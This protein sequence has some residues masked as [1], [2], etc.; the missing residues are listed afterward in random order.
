MSWN[1]ST[2]IGG[3]IHVET[4][5]SFNTIDSGGTVGANVILEGGTFDVDANTT[6]SGILTHTASST[7]DVATG[8][9]LTYSHA[10]VVNIGANTLNLTGPGSIDITGGGAFTLNDANSKLQLTGEASTSTATISHVAVGTTDLTN[11]DAIDLVSDFTISNFETAANTGITLAAA[12]TLTIGGTVS[13]PSGKT[14]TYT[15]TSGGTLKFTDTL[16][17]A[18]TFTTANGA[19]LDLQGVDVT[20]S[21]DLDTSAA[22]GSLLTDSTT[23]LTLTGS[24]ATRTLTTAAAHTVQSVTFDTNTLA[25]GD[26]NSDLTVIDPVAIAASGEGITTNGADLS[27]SDTL[28]LSAGTLSSSG[29]TVTVTGALT[30]TN[31]SL[32]TSG[33]SL[34]LNGT[35]SGGALDVSNTTVTQNGDL[36][37]SGLSGANL[38]NT[39][40]TINTQTNTLTWDGQ[41]NSLAETLNIGNGTTGAV[42]NI[43]GSTANTITAAIALNGG[44]FDIDGDTTLSGTL[45][46]TADSTIDI[47]DGIHFYYSGSAF[48]IGA[49]TLTISGGGIINNS[50]ALRLDNPASILN[51]TG[52]DG[53][54]YK[55]EITGA[56]STG[57]IDADT[58]YVILDLLLSSTA[59]NVD[60]AAGK[61]LIIGDTLY[62][63]ADATLTIN[64]TGTFIL[65]D[66]ALAGNLDINGTAILSPDST[67]I[68]NADSTFSP[69]AN[70]DFKDGLIVADGI[71]FTIDDTGGTW[72]VTF[73]GGLDLGSGA[74][75]VAANDESIIIENSILD[76]TTLAKLSG[77]VTSPTQSDPKDVLYLTTRPGNGAVYLS[78]A[79]Q[80]GS[81]DRVLIRR[82]T[83]DF[84]DATTDEVLVFDEDSTVDTH[85]DGIANGIT[86]GTKY[87][88][89]AFAHNGANSYAPGIKAVAAA[90]MMPEDLVG[91]YQF[92]GTS[93]TDDSSGRRNHGVVFGTADSTPDLQDRTDEAF[94]FGSDGDYMD[95]DNPF[96]DPTGDVQD[97]FTIS[98]WLKTG[99]TAG[100]DAG[101]WYDGQSV[102]DGRI[103]ENRNDFG[104]S[105]GNGKVLFGTGNSG[106][107][108]TIVSAS[109]V[110]DDS[111]HAVTVTRS[112][113]SG[114][115][116]VY[117]DGIL[118]NSGAMAADV[119][120]Y[121]PYLLRIGVQPYAE[122]YYEG[123]I[124]EIRFYQTVLSEVEVHKLYSYP[125]NLTL[126][127]TA[128]TTCYDAA[129]TEISCP[130]PDLSMAQDGSYIANQLSFTE[131]GDSTVSDNVT[132]L[133]WQ[134]SDDNTARSYVNAVTEC[135]DST[136]GGFDDWR[137]P[138]ARELVR[139]V[140][141][142]AFSPAL[143]Y[144]FY[145]TDNAEYWSGTADLLN[146]GNYWAIDATDGS[147]LSAIGTDT[148]LVRCVRG[149]EA[150]ASNLEIVGET[151]RDRSTGLVWQQGDVSADSDW[152]SA[153]D[154][155]EGLVH[156]TMLDWRLP[157]VKELAS[158]IDYTDSTAPIIS[159]DFT[160]RTT[161]VCWAA[162][163]LESSPDS[164]WMVD[165]DSGS[166]STNTKSGT[167]NV[168]CVRGGVVAMV[169]DPGIFGSAFFGTDVYGD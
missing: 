158:I 81:Y 54:L 29:G 98:F 164:A 151:I 148:K 142:G 42:F 97:D 162:T 65:H 49:H 108:K 45:T 124:D 20:L 100:S 147:T 136:L 30:M 104:V 64:G 137:L 138:N 66:I 15:G 71:A 120:L 125:L 55:V 6:L 19:I 127:H 1:G 133:R 52:A 39:G 35:I 130:D 70:L 95:I 48:G 59:A 141:Y 116:K 169:G 44:T 23:T 106:T 43:T 131:M 21:T 85:T 119:S 152:E 7:I 58:D 111:W 157:N 121:D 167:Q 123:A 102:V 72:T 3:D 78:W 57:K 27:L 31:G 46:H 160:N 34:N 92:F 32:T 149:G 2:P 156:E 146:A 74:T 11:A 79:Y 103:D 51:L 153:T 99:Q 128:Q 163:N 90:D 8:I 86:N 91:Y 18:G 63:F 9:T 56:L 60:I 132:G 135:A 12:K 105:L 168:R 87:Y 24:S 75:V 122:N 83:T 67:L 76:E 68:V 53:M 155:C 113:A 10:N 144:L 126:P 37:L 94:Y 25:L 165:F 115:M 16:T 4:N 14:F 36:S 118:D 77:N 80:S 145:F 154:Y 109:S 159:T 101:D 61:T 89:T 107:D 112:K 69:G 47:L 139:M 82:D 40:T 117:I 93:N 161:H 62:T 110:A 143:D 88:Y 134:Q 129:G 140:N 50:N 96:I 84:P 22:G 33:G 41:G 5:G 73:A 150:T 26:G 166:I 28:S 13:L 17:I 38:I 114:N